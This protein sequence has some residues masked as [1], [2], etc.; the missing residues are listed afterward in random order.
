MFHMLVEILLGF[1]KSRFTYHL[2]FHMDAS[3]PS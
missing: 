3:F 1:F 2:L